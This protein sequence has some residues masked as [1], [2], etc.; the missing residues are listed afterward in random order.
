MSVIRLF[1]LGLWLVK[2]HMRGRLSTVLPSSRV[3][4]G[5]SFRDLGVDIGSFGSGSGGCLLIR[6]VMMCALSCQGL[7][8]MQFDPLFACTL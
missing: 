2:L 6:D 4:L 5:V 3:R 8:V 1:I 7:D